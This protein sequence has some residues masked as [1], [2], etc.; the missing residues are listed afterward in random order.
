MADTGSQFLGRL[1]ANRRTP[2]L[3]R[4]PDGSYLSALGTVSSKPESP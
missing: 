4:L 2:V 1:R 3:T